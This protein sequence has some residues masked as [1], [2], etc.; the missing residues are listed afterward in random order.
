MLGS[1]TRRGSRWRRCGFS[2]SDSEAEREIHDR[3]DA[4][5]LDL[6]RDRE[7][8]GTGAGLTVR[9]HG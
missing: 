1:E 4:H 7:L 2:A 8:L 3:L 5:I 6:L 9:T